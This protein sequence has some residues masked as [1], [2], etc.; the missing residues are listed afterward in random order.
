MDADR[1]LP[2]ATAIIP[3]PSDDSNSNGNGKRK[4]DKYDLNSGSNRANK[5]RKAVTFSQEGSNTTTTGSKKKSMKDKKNPKGKGIRRV[6]TR[7]LG[8]AEVLP[9]ILT[10]RKLIKQKK[11]MKDE[12]VTIVKMLTGTLYLYRGERPRAEFVRFT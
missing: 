6:G 11:E 2:Q 12:N 10:K 3:T 5:E 7:S 1:L 4:L 8:Y 9:E